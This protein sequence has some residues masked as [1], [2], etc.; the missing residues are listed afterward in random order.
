MCIRD[1]PYDGFKP[2]IGRIAHWRPEA[3]PVRVDHGIAEDGEISPYYD[4]MVA[5]FIAHGHDRHDALRRLVRAL[6]DAPLLG[7]TNNGRYLCDVVQHQDFGAAR[8]TTTRLDEWAEAGEASL[9][10]PA[11]PEQ[12]WQL[13][14]ALFAPQAATRAASLTRDVYKRQPACSTGA[15]W[16][17][18]PTTRSA[19]PTVIRAWSAS[20][21]ALTR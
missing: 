19:R 2:Q 16:A 11:P 6:Q 14:A 12:A 17:S 10:R 4:A 20:A 1:S 9:T 7:V 3:T 8:M 18:P 15:A 21:V 13:A 5:K